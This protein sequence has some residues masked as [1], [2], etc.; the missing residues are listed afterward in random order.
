MDGYFKIDAANYSPVTIMENLWSTSIVQCFSF[1]NNWKRAE[2]IMGENV[3]SF[4]PS[5]ILFIVTEIYV[6]NYF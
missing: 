5:S 2:L 6:T 4:Y 3:C 1:A